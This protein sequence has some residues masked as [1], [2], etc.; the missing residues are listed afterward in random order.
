MP[1]NPCTHSMPFFLAYL[2]GEAVFVAQM[3]REVL[4]TNW[5]KLEIHP[6]PKYLMPDPVESLEAAAELVKLGFVVLPYVHA[7]PVLVNTAIAS[8]GDPV[9]MAAA[10]RMAVEAGRLARL[11]RLAPVAAAAS[12]TS[13]LTAF[14]EADPA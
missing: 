9:A 12:A 7:D 14:L 5:L 3:A 11:A 10:F 13:P 2:A 4:D 1:R 6:D 8:A